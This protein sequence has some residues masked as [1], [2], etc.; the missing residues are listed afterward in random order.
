MPVDDEATAFSE[1]RQSTGARGN[2]MTTAELQREVQQRTL[3]S[4]DCDA[5]SATVAEMTWLLDDLC[6][7]LSLHSI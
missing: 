6:P 4:S 7:L 1:A 2:N 3:T 5:S